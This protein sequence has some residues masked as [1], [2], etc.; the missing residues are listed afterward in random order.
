MNIPGQGKRLE[1]SR[2]YLRSYRQFSVVRIQGRGDGRSEGRE[3][4]GKTVELD[5]RSLNYLE[6][7][8][9]TR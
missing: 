4:A 8:Q 1:H 5:Y 7:A 2:A 9:V 3:E 6:L